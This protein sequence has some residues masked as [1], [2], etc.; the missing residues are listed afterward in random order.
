[1]DNI[2]NNRILIDYF[3]FVSKIDDERTIIRLLGLED[4]PFE[5]AP[6]LYFYSKSLRYENKII[7]LFGGHKFKDANG[8][9]CMDNNVCVQMSGK[10]CRV[11]ETNSKYSFM[12]LIKYL[13]ENS[14]DY[15]ITRID[16][17]YDDFSGI[18]DMQTL[19]SDVRAKNYITKT[20][21]WKIEE[22]SDGSSIYFGSIH[23]L[24]RLR[25]YDKAAEQ[26]INDG[27]HW[28]RV[29]LQL[30]DDRSQAIVNYINSGI[31]IDEVYFNALNNYI[32]FVEPS[33]DTNKSR[34]NLKSYWD[35]FLEYYGK[36]SLYC[37]P[38]DY[39]CNERLEKFVRVQCSA[40]VSSFV[41]IYG[42][43]P[44]LK[45]LYNR[46]TQDINHK[47]VNLLVQNNTDME[48]L[49]FEVSELLG[50]ELHTIGLNAINIPK[51]IVRC[52]KCGFIGDSEYFA[53]YGGLG[54]Y[55]TGICFNCSRG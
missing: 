4:L 42:L 46:S 37:E 6:G 31:C 19:I 17:A 48:H 33:E 49:R 9:I 2:E 3:T 8:K 5:E 32:R 23:S 55:N 21:K 47:Y 50:D 11:F 13:Y 15:N 24:I 25:I 26:L 51:R 39:Y 38:G 12:D 29:E 45:L 53:T 52:E 40:A 54:R 30:R 41:A 35:K 44:F 28:V 27:T 7:I 43:K 22:G 36:L 34:W 16:L 20:R 1:M 10:G 14:D 18:F